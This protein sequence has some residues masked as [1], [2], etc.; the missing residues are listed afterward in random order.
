MALI[1]I[2]EDT[3]EE[4]KET[5]Q[6]IKISELEEKLLEVESTN[7]LCRDVETFYNSAPNKIKPFI[8]LI[9]EEDEQK[10]RDKIKLYKEL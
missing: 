6:I 10:L 9:P 1:K 5:K 7:K 4:V 3:V 2:D 8:T